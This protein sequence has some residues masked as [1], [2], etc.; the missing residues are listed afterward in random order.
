MTLTRKARSLPPK[1]G[2]AAD[3]FVRRVGLARVTTL[4]LALGLSL[5]ALTGPRLLAATIGLSAAVLVLIGQMAAGRSTGKL[6]LSL[7]GIAAV[8]LLGLFSGYLLGGVRAQSLAGSELARWRG[9]TVDATLTVTGQVKASGRWVNATAMIDSASLKTGGKTDR[10]AQPESARGE[11][12]LLE[13]STTD[14][15]TVPIRQGEILSVTGSIKEPE[16]ES[17][18]GFNQRSYLRNQGIAIVLSANAADLR[19]LGY[20]GG[21]T[22]FFDRLRSSSK[23]HLSR[24]PDAR[25]DELAQ[26]IVMG[27]TD[28]LDSGW[29][30]AFRRSGTAHM[31]SVSGLHV[32]ALA[33]IMIG[34]AKLA[35]APRSAGFL[36]AAVACLLMVPFV[37]ASPPVVRSVVMII[38]VLF[39]RWVGRRRDQWQVLGL[40]ATVVLAINPYALF[41]PGFQLSFAAFS[42]MVLLLSPLQRVLRFLPQSVGGNVAVS[43]A[44]SVGTAPVSL[45]VFGRMSIVAV[46]AN[47]LVV[48]TLPA[49]TG[50]GMASIVAGFAWPGLS[51][52]LD[53]AMSPIL[54]WTVEMSRLFGAA[55]V[56]ETDQLSRAA[57]ALMLAVLSLPAAAALAGRTVRVPFGLPLPLFRR[58][59][60]WLY[61][62]RPRKRRIAVAL[63]A[64]LPALVMTAGWAAYPPLQHQLVRASATLTG[65]WP[66]TVEVRV[67]DVGQGNAI[68]V[69]TPDKHAFLF[70]GG[71]EGCGLGS[72]LRSLGVTTLDLVVITHP[73]ADHFAGLLECLDN[74]KVGTILDDTE[75]LAPQPSYTAAVPGAG[76]ACDYLELR[77]KL[78]DAGARHVL[79]HTGLG[80]SADGMALRVFAP[81][82][83]LEMVDSRNPWALQA[84]PPTGDEMNAGSVICV[85]SVGESDFL[86]PGDA[87]AATLEKNGLPHVEVFVVPHHGSSG[88]VS[89]RLLQELKPEAA[90]VSVGEDNPFGHPSATTMAALQGSIAAVLRTD[91]VGWVSFAVREGSIEANMERSA[92][93]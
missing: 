42:G 3:W 81:P 83:P 17:E 72:Q 21:I 11:A 91:Q 6:R 74:L 25:L 59:T 62:R 13:V 23:S 79:A 86:L 1:A 53:Y 10:A 55:P 9:A 75:I 45:V 7:A 48:P 22:G 93:S 87:E 51:T 71:P 80:I 64:V 19:T 84:G 15:Q 38:I 39:G 85:L 90:V 44:A 63:C 65:A 89:S 8:V 58:A 12:V 26:G 88:G 36:L 30:E 92:G 50:L 35:R 27:D 69:R 28:G 57:A 66:D 20:R 2:R 33:A 78:E 16:G 73:H 60:R 37:G 41:D 31:L 40:A 46:F 18:S 77:H 5:A 29:T 61:T 14:D 4:S 70:D 76:E 24:G 54:A 82:R 47:L 49:V 68:L 67:L 52:A 56:L 32:A 43:L 34:L